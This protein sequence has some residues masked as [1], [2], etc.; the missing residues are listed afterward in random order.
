[1]RQFQQ[2]FHRELKDLPFTLTRSGEVFATVLQ[3]EL[4]EPIPS[5]Q[6]VPFT[7]QVKDRI[8]QHT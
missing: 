6:H 1:M 3:G 7:K 4:V 2:N 8:Y 5:K